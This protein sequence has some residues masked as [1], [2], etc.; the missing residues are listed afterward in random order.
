MKRMWSKNELKAISDARVKS[1]VEGGTLDNAKPIY[2][3][4]ISVNVTNL[5]GLTAR[6]CAYIFNNDKTEFTKES[7]VAYINDV[8]NRIL[9]NGAIFTSTYYLAVAF[10]FKSASDI[11]ISGIDSK[12][13][14]HTSN[15]NPISFTTLLSTSA[16]EITDIVV[17]IN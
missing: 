9:M 1:L 15:L 5:D 12:G 11:F 7:L 8:E 17:K 2:K 16:S 3:H 13:D 4:T 14:L 10:V 6:M